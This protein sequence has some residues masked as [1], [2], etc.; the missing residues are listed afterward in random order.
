MQL[1][2]RSRN[3]HV[4]GPVVGSFQPHAVTTRKSIKCSHI[5]KPRI[6]V[7]LQ[8]DLSNHC[9]IVVLFLRSSPP[10]ISHSGQDGLS[11][12]FFELQYFGSDS[13]LA[14]TKTST[15]IRSVQNVD[16]QIVYKIQTRYKMQTADWVQNAD[17]GF[18]LVLSDRCWY[19]SEITS[20]PALHTYM[21]VQKKS[22]AYETD[23][24]YTKGS[25]PVPCY[26]ASFSW[27]DTI[28]TTRESSTSV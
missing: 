23:Q 13:R 18:I 24:H 9:S 6:C 8:L 12:I 1:E 10:Y 15:P 20:T 19:I 28:D 21:Y 14:R 17:W 2:S 4:K 22:R 16:L 26:S 11:K 3:V 25:R 27:R 7:R 5:G